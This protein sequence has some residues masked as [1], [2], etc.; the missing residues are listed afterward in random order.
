MIYLFNTIFY[1]P[2]FNLLVFLYNS[3]TFQDLGIAIILLTVI[4]KLILWPLSRKSIKSQQSL[5][6]L[7]PKIDALKAKHK[8]NQQEMGKEM[9]ALYKENK[10]NPFS[11]C[12]PLILQLPFFI[13]VYQ[14]LSKGLDNN[15]EMLYPFIT[16]P[17]VIHPFLLDF[18]DLSRPNIYLAVLAG[19]AQFWQAKM[20]MAKRVDVKTGGEGSKDEN[21]AA[22]MSKQMVYFMPAL[23]VFIGITLPGGLTL[24]WLTITLLTVLQQVLMGKKLPKNDPPAIEG[25]IIQ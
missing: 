23:T 25:Q 10:I 9:M 5:Q 7:Q 19:A 13:A 24:Y 8:G 12:L 1:Q 4:I 15:F 2:I 17:E 14:V 20:M 16:R 18:L 22:I 6:T 11:S 21:M 3:V